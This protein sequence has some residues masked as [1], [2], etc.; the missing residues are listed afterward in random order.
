MKP[1]QSPGYARLTVNYALQ[2]SLIARK[3]DIE[4][5]FRRHHARARRLSERRS[6]V[7][8]VYLLTSMG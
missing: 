3:I 1:E 2:Q 4:E 8:P 6:R 5:L 7:T